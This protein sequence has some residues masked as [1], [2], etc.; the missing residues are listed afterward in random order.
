MVDDHMA[1]R[2]GPETR[3]GYRD[4][5]P[6]GVAR[7]LV[8]HLLVALLIVLAA[9]RPADPPAPTVLVVPIDLVRPGA[10]TGGPPAPQLAAVPQ[11]QAHEEAE[12]D[13]DRAV[14]A[15]ETPP[16]PPAPRRAELTASPNLKPPP[17]PEP[18]SATPVPAR[19]PRRDAS[20]AARLE[21]QNL[22]ADDL[23]RKLKSLA[24]LRQP[25]PP[26]PPDPRRQDGQGLSNVAAT[27][28]DAGRTRDASYA[29][30]DFIRAQ[31]E[32]R[33]NFRL[34][35]PGSGDWVVMIHIELDPDGSV[36]DAEVVDYPRYRADG[37]YRDF[38]LSARNAVLMSSPLSVPP[39]DYDIAKDIV[40]D[41]S[42]RKAAE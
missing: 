28:A 12:P 7:S 4:W 34:D 17:P 29:V 33:W 36:R 26:V 1:I 27:S 5:M 6:G 39:G 14:P 8:L 21:E 42:A 11:E 24:K 22:P 15:A 9:D 38:A 18:A 31:V 35:N 37:P 10:T 19:A 40:V 3:I 13:H 23:S 30:R 20:P 2:F 16:P 41:F 32:R 25:A